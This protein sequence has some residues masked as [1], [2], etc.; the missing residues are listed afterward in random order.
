MAEP[1]HQER[2]QPS[3]LDR[4]TDDYAVRGILKNAVGTTEREVSPKDETSDRQVISA[5]KLRELVKRDLSWL[6]NTG[7]L[8]DLADLSDFPLVA[9]SVINY[10]IPDLAGL[11][12]SNADTFEIER[13]LRKA[14]IQY[15]PRILKDSLRVTASITNQMSNKALQFEIECDIC[16]QP[17][18]EHLYLKSEVDLDTG[19]IKLTDRMGC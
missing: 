18:P 17:V 2:V 12:I 19:G 1:Y 7:C 9:Q 6:L 4:L 10:G 3:L 11:S 5:R 15:E 14:I 16:G 13:R 8:E